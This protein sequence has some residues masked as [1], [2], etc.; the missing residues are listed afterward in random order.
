MEE[1]EAYF[2]AAGAP[3]APGVPAKRKIPGLGD[4]E[5]WKRKGVVGPDETSYNPD[6]E[7]GMWGLECPRCS[8][9]KGSNGAPLYTSDIGMA[10]HML[11]LGSTPG[12]R[13]PFK[14][15]QQGVLI[16]HYKARCPCVWDEAFQRADPELIKTITSEAHTRL[17]REEKAARRG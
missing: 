15:P 4:W 8:K 11:S 1:Q 5:L 3:G 6:S 7:D 12:N 9:L 2:G 13:V 10:A 14:P 16:R 17:V